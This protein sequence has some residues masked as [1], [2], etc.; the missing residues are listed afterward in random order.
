MAEKENQVF[1]YG[2]PYFFREGSFRKE[3]FYARQAS[4]ILMTCTGCKN[5][6]SLAET[7]HC[8]VYCYSHYHID[9]ST[10]PC[11]CVNT[12]I[13]GCLSPSLPSAVSLSRR[14]YIQL[15]MPESYMHTSMTDHEQQI[16]ILLS[17][18]RFKYT[19]LPIMTPGYK[20]SFPQDYWRT[21][22]LLQIKNFS[23][24]K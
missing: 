2:K 12:P 3:N 1:I 6:I 13:P 18:R 17:I 7:R 8:C 11:Y 22:P 10:L 4:Y 16:K 5:E 19:R 15:S 9:C 20:L 23:R 14:D 24:Y 21:A